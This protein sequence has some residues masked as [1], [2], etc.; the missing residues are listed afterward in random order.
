MSAP[1]GVYVVTI[2][3][4]GYVMGTGADFDTLEYGGCT[5]EESQAIR[6]RK[7]AQ[8]D[9]VK[10]LCS[11]LVTDC[12]DEYELVKIW[13]ALARKGWKEHVGSI[14]WLENLEPKGGA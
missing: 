2:S 14:G 5:L 1:K 7:R 8:C 6:A 3:P 9:T 4:G 12:L 10:R 13:D 11:A